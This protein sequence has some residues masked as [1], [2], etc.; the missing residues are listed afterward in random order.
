[1][2]GGRGQRTLLSMTTPFTT[3][4]S[5]QLEPTAHDPFVDDIAPV[6][7][8]DSRSADGIQVALLWRPGDPDVT[9][10]VDDVKTGVRFELPVPGRDALH[11][12]HHPF[13]YAA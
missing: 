11:A 7:E 10:R 2:S 3:E 12:F 13:A 6:R 9:V 5:L 4:T 1:M 8:L